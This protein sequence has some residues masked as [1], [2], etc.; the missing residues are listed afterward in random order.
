MKVRDAGE[1]VGELDMGEELTGEGPGYERGG[2]GPEGGEEVEV[3]EAGKAVTA[4]G[5]EYEGGG[6]GPGYGGRG[7]E[8]R[9]K[10]RGEGPG[11]GKGSGIRIWV[12]WVRVT[13]KRS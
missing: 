2:E 4:E 12:V 6:E 7:D 10:E 5:P 8:P 3:R 1:G 11:C 9:Y 13:G